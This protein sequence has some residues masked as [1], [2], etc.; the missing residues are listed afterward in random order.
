[1]A[2]VRLDQWLDV[3]CLFKTRSEAQK[4]CRLGKVSV[5]GAGRQ[6]APRRPGRRRARDPSAARAQ[7]ARDGA[8]PR[9]HVISRKP[10]RACFTKIARRSRRPRKSRSA[11]SSASIGPPRRPRPGP[12][13]TA[14]DPAPSQTRGVISS[15]TRLA[16]RFESSSSSRPPRSSSLLPATLDFLADWLWFGEVGY[17]QVYSTAI[18]ARA[19]A[20][21]GGFVVAM[22][23]L[24]AH[25]RLAL[26][27]M[28]PA[29]LAFTTR[30]GFSVALPTRDQVR[31]LVM[32]L[33]AI[34]SFLI[35]SFAASQWMTLLTWWNQVPFGKADPILG[36]D[37]SMYVFTLPA[38]ELLRGMLF[39]LVLL[40]A[41]GVLGLYFVSSQVALTPFGLRIEPRA[42]R[43]L[44]WLAAALFLVLA[45]GAWIG[46][47][48]EIVSPSGIIQGASLRRRAR[49]DAGRA[50]ADA[51]V[52]RRRGIVG[53]DRDHRVDP[54][55]DHR[56]GAVCA[57]AA[58]RR[59]V[60]EPPAAL[61]GDAERAGPRNAVHGIQHRG[62]ARGLSRSIASRSASCRAKHR[63]RSR[64]SRTT[65]P[66]STTCASGITSRC[67]RRSDRSRRS[68]PTT[69][70][71][72]ST[73]IAIRSTARTGR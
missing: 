44:A 64:T 30:E 9:R 40:A 61:R 35:A 54:S 72:R 55:R 23:W 41:V 1:M 68:A 70:S 60:C 5:N 25:A 53:R 26:A 36:H 12:I 24:T 33:A 38:L 32:I 67:S 71:S 17:R 51:G 73:T 50:R 37:A 52:D 29:P 46:R 58:R 18:T 49:P 62:D 4:A 19:V 7:A 6:A 59:R 63:S 28:S 45:L 2:G 13:A 66:R 57:G 27:A 10:R 48:Q 43:H 65:A 39:G 11:G 42:R 16:C 14:T 21:T 8:R 3:A 31:P 69:T 20:W 22:A 34:A 56:R 47:L 15:K